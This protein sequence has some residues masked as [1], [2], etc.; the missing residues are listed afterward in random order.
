MTE[1]RVDYHL[2]LWSHWMDKGTAKGETYP[3]EA[4]G[5]IQC[6]TS[7][8]CTDEAYE[9]QCDTWAWATDSVIDGLETVY[10]AAIY[11]QLLQGPWSLPSIVLGP[12]F[13]A[14][15]EMVGRGLDKKGIE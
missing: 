14:A 2:W 7:N 11:A 4:S 8:T 15:S 12:H 1:S 10:K 5:G 3:H 13:R 6:Y 9:R